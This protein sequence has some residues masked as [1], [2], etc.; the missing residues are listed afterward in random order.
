MNYMKPHFL[1]SL[2]GFLWLL[3]GVAVAGQEAGKVVF[4]TGSVQV[5]RNGAMMSLGKDAV[6]EVGDRIITGADGHAHLRMSDQG[7]IGVRPGSRL[8]IEA[9][10]YEAASPAASRVRIFLESGTS[11]TVSGRAGEAAR[12]H[13]RFNTPVA[14]IGLRGTDYVVFAS[15]EVTRVSVLRGA[16][17]VSPLGEGCSVEG[18]GACNGPLVR[19]LSAATPH[20]YL[21][22]RKGGMAPQIIESE[23]NRD[24]P[25]KVTPPHPGEGSVQANRE[26]TSAQVAGEVFVPAAVINAPR[27]EIA[28]GR[29]SSVA[30]PN[31]PTLVSQLSDDREITFSNDL[32]GLV[33]PAGTPRLPTG[34]EISMSYAHG[35]AYLRTAAPGGGVLSPV[36]LSNGRLD[37]DFNRRQ[38]ATSLTAATQAGAVYDLQAQG[39]IHWQGMLLGDPG[40]SNM[41]VSGALT[42]D[43]REAGYLFDAR[44]NP[45][46]TLIG[47]T[48]WKR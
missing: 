45:A 41:N 44:V 10:N 28:W 43:A 25:S 32:F 34:G 18:G 8:H 39:S 15:T 48:R 26:Y 21:E 4:A 29:W 13:Y 2:L 33:R 5:E 12:E 35:D 23:S 47:A 46:Q 16:V 7:F 36:A 22:V 1:T 17:A 3:T 24:A 20:A 38:F 6:V 30:L 27:P 31:T 40:R 42:N 37:L 14:A 19:E 11:R 9:Y